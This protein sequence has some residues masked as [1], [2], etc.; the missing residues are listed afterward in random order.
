[1]LGSTNCSEKENPGI[2]LPASQN[3]FPTG[4]FPAAGEFADLWDQIDQNSI[5]TVN[6]IDH[7]GIPGT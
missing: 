4:E 2:K 5:G 1:M 3:I 6:A 7:L